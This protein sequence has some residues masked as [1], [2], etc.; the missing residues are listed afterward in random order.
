MKISVKLYFHGL[1]FM[2]FY[3]NDLSPIH[4]SSLIIATDETINT[5]RERE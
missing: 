4:I 5:K 2:I 3:R 1:I